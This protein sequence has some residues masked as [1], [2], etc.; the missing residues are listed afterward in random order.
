M[1]RIAFHIIIVQ[2]V[3]SVTQLF[4]WGYDE[5]R[6]ITRAA[7]QAVSGEFGDFLIKNIEDLSYH[8]ADPDFW[9]A[10]DPNEGYRHFIDA[11]LYAQYPFDTIPRNIDSL[12]SKYGKENIS[13]W[14]IAPW[15]IDDYCNR[16][17]E[18]FRTGQWEESIYTM[19]ALSHY[20]ADIH[21]PLHTC[22]NY[23]GQLTGNEGVHF[24]WETPIVAQYVTYI[25]PL[26]EAVVI[27]DLLE[28]AFTIVKESY[29]V[30]PLLLSADSLA[31]APLTKIQADS[32]NTYEKLS[33]EDEYLSV[34]Y[35][36]TADVVHDRLNKSA[37][38]I[39]SYWY[40]CWVNAG[41]PGIGD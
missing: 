1:R 24:R 27:P 16:L 10:A 40:T 22:A 26:N 23:N 39:A 19:A 38:R 15:N 14:G 34:L 4:G 33:F 11:D 7:V 13:H 8:A 41:S 6:R 2:L 21:M 12:Y 28:M 29:Q 9:K 35:L 3:F 30:Y 32:L 17:T 18:L 36:Q 25:E 37:E 31:R 20:V 5:H